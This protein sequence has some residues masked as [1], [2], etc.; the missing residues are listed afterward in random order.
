[1]LRQAHREDIRDMHRVRI[2]VRENRLTLAVITEA[3]YLPYLQDHGRGWVV[4]TTGTVR[5]F[6]IGDARDGSVWA[7]FV[8]PEH[9]RRGYGRQ[10]HEALVSWLWA[11]GHARL[12]LTT[13]PGTRAERFYQAAGWQRA[14]ATAGGELRFELFRA[15]TDCWACQQ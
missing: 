11:Q 15:R 12:W 7:L 5:G 14:G 6:A 1:M 8:D 9:D 2:S 10:L 3:D 4:E 13:D